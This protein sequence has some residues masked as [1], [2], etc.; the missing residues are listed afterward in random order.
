[1]ALHIQQ[2]ACGDAH[3]LVLL[4]DGSVWAAGGNRHGQLGDGTRVSK[5][6]WCSVMPSG[7]E[8]IQVATGAHH[9]LA[10]TSD[11]SVW[12][13]GRN[14]SGQMG[15]GKCVDQTGWVCVMDSGSEV[16]RLSAGRSHSLALKSDGSVWAA[17]RNKEGQLG[18]RSNV[19]KK[20]WFCVIPSGSEVVEI[21]TGSDHSLV[22]KTDGSVWATGWNAHAQLGDG[23]TKNK[24]TWVSVIPS[25]VTKVVAG[26]YHSLALKSDGAVWG[27]GYNKFGQLGV[28][29]AANSTW[30]SVL[31]SGVILLAA[32]DQHSLALKS[33]GVLWATG[34][35]Y[36]GQLG[37]GTETSTPHWVTVF[38]TGV[39]QVA[40]G[41]YHSLALKADGTLWATGRNNCGQLG[42][43]GWGSA[44]WIPDRFFEKLLLESLMGE[45]GSLSDRMPES[46]DDCQGLSL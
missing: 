8:V 44:A 35:N 12:A 32:G 38:A 30:T 17:G 46:T 10:L 37:D 18:V 40:G 43:D 26:D 1:M 22:L 4:S 20:S 13:A 42:Q 11:G 3:S 16:I 29:Y 34:Y 41:M 7:S 28:P 5:K 39:V 25:D 24:S 15:D 2:M 45:S 27:V 33:D 31:A 36:F 23:T 6:T 9:S 21:A 14:D 19:N